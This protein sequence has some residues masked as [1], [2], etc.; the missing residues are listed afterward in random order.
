M[1]LNPRKTAFHGTKQKTDPRHSSTVKILLRICG[2]PAIGSYRG[3][4][5]NVR[6]AF[7][8]YF[9]PTI[10]CEIETHLQGNISQYNLFH[11][12]VQISSP[13]DTE[14]RGSFNFAFDSLTCWYSFFRKHDTP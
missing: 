11:K 2:T 7:T 12:V 13:N 6:K 1:F 14:F 10:P 3:A 8:P 4:A 9:I 5:K